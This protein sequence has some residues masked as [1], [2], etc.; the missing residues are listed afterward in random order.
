MEALTQ[1]ELNRITREIN[2]LL[3][4]AQV[5]LFGSYATGK[6]TVGSDLDLC[7]VAAEFPL[8]RL[9]MMDC[10]R[11]AIVD[12]TKRPIDILLFSRSEFER[13]SRRKPTIEYVIAQEG[14]LLNG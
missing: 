11:D 8:R 7:I 9:D 13:N 5:F 12:K 2:T 4:G 14:V 3:P 10:I 1:I 6:Q